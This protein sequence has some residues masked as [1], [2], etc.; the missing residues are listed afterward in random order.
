MYIKGNRYNTR[1]PTRAKGQNDKE[2]RMYVKDEIF[3]GNTM[4]SENPV[5]FDYIG[6]TETDKEKKHNK[7]GEI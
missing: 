5:N 1:I 2:P 7:R 6:N 4:D 3:E